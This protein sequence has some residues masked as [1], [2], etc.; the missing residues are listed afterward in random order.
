ML[1]RQHVVPPGQRT[2]PEGKYVFLQIQRCLHYKN[3]SAAVNRIL[4]SGGLATIF[5][6]LEPAQLRYL[7]RFAGKSLGYT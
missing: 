4:I 7:V 1:L 6:G 5:A 2:Y 3:L